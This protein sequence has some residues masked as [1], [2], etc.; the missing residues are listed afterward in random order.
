VVP[1][2]RQATVVV[3]AVRARRVVVDTPPEA[4]VVDI[5]QVVAVDIRL[6]VAVAV[7]TPAAVAIPVAVIAKSGRRCQQRLCASDE[8]M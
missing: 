4:V 2:V 5:P 8:L 1:T 3:V 7:D 6:V